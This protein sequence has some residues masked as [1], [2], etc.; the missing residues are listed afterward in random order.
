[1]SP[2]I[3]SRC[4]A[5]YPHASAA[6]VH[7]SKPLSQTSPH[8]TSPPQVPKP[9][10]AAPCPALRRHLGRGG[11]V[12]SA[13]PS[14]LASGRSAPTPVANR[15]KVNPYTF[16]TSSPAKNFARAAGFRRAR[17]LHCFRDPIASPRFFLS[18]DFSVNKGH[19]CDALKRSRGLGV[20]PYLK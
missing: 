9:S 17:R 3:R 18:R 10:H 2:A 14:A 5:A 19:T 15:D 16:S 13:S 20:K 12:V 11:R 6:C 8:S 1:V 4:G 7:C